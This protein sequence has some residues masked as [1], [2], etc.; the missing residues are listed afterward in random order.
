MV[1][2]GNELAFVTCQAVS[3]TPGTKYNPLFL[4]GGSGV[5]KPTSCKA[6]GNAYLEAHP[7]AKVLYVS[8]EQFIQE[9]VDAIKY[10]KNI[11]GGNHYRSADMLIVDD[12]QFMAGKDRTEEEFFI[13]I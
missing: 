5:G 6:A 13:H 3:R 7:D 12:I 4:Y 11:R 10:K 1:G 2:P 9:F 8:T